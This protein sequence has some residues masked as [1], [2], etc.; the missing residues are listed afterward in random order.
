LPKGEKVGKFG[1][2]KIR[3]TKSSSFGEGL[4]F[5]AYVQKTGEKSIKL[6]FPKY[7]KE[8]QKLYFEE[9]RKKFYEF[10]NEGP[11]NITVYPPRAHPRNPFGDPTNAPLAQ[12]G[13]LTS[14]YLMAFS[15]YG[16]RYILQTCLDPV[17]EYIQQSF[18]KKV[19]ERLRFEETKDTCVQFCPETS[20]YREDPEIGLAIYLDK[21]V[22]CFQEIWF[23]NYHVRLPVP[24][25]FDGENRLEIVVQFLEL[26][27]RATENIKDVQSIFCNNVCVSGLNHPLLSDL[28]KFTKP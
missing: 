5:E 16:Y 27:G 3:V 14:A 7:G 21:N 12:A 8:S 25:M 10:A 19:D 6:G 2:R 24:D 15:E 17:R 26:S 13:F 23:L 20:H 22:P 18:E 1:L 4:G 11:I 9:Q 28:Q